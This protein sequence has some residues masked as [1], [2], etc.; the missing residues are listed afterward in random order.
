MAVR[1]SKKSYTVDVSLGTDKI[2]GK[3]KRV[4]KKGIKTYGKA[5]EIEAQLIQTKYSNNLLFKELCILYL[6]DSK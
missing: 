2:T 4:V 1:K 5:K 3:R 6:C